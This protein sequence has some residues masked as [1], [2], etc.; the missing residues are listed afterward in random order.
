MEMSAQC[1]CTTCL[2]AWLRVGAEAQ[3]VVKLGEC[4]NQCVEVYS[5]SNCRVFFQEQSPT[6]HEPQRMEILPRTKHGNVHH[7]TARFAKSGSNYEN[8][9]S[10]RN[11]ERTLTNLLAL[12]QRLLFL[13]RFASVTH[14]FAA[15]GGAAAVACFER[16][17]H[18][19]GI[20]RPRL[21]RGRADRER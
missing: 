14:Q 19:S 20:G 7:F 10:G 15:K 2:V 12:P 18:G 9:A 4:F 16:A 17:P 5:A 13:L 21:P 8:V 6:I 11:I 3:A 1:F